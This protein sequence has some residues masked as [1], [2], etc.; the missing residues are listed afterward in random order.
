[1]KIT[2]IVPNTNMLKYLIPPPHASSDIFVENKLNH[3][4]LK[5]TNNNKETSG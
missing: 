3:V 2:R 4:S 5:S 1:M